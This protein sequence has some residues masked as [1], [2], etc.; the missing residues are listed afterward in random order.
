MNGWAKGG[1]IGFVVAFVGLILLLFVVGYE[2]GSWN[3]STLKGPATCGFFQF[4]ISPLHWAFI[5]FFSWIGFAGGVVDYRLI[6]KI[7][8]KG[9]DARK[10]PLKITSVITLTLVIVFSI[11]GLIAFENW[12]TIMV[13]AVLFFIFVLFVS[14]AV[15]KWKYRN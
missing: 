6:K 11:V 13:Y 5:L 3:C 9:G 4:I 15:G 7:I 12:V 14:W 10:I 8:R 2:D 1:F